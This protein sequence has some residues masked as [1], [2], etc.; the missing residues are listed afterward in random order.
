MPDS[1]KSGAPAAQSDPNDVVRLAELIE[2]VRYAMFTSRGADG[3]LRARPLTTLEVDR[4]ASLTL[5][6][7][8]PTDGDIA[9]EVQADPQVNVSYSSPAKDIYAS[10]AATAYLSDDLPRKRALWN[11]MVQA[12]FPGGADDPASVLLVAEL[13]GAEYWHVEQGKVAQIFQMLKAAAK[14]AQP[15]LDAEHRKFAAP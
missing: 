9:R 12:W 15:E 10:I 5:T 3:E 1:A 13:Q 11:A 2:S 8:I 4:G 14:G 7:L 6:F